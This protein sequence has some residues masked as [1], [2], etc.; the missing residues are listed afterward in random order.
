MDGGELF[1][2][3]GGAWGTLWLLSDQRKGPRLLRSRVATN[4]SF[5]GPIKAELGS[6]LIISELNRMLYLHLHEEVLLASILLTTLIEGT[7]V[8]W[9]SRRGR[10]PAGT[11]HVCLI[12]FI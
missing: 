8:H 9:S 3:H 10:L 5:Q 6:Y 12:Y 1:P 11:S 7:V 4:G 2:G